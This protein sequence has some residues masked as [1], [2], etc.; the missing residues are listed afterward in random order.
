MNRKSLPGGFLYAGSPA[1]PVR[2]VSRAEV[3]LLAASLRGRRADPL[4]AAASLP[5]LGMTTF[6][7]GSDVASLAEAV[8]RI[9]AATEPGA[10]R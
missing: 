6:Q 7:I 8:D 1:K 2:E 3:A 5:P 9:M 4:L 10:P